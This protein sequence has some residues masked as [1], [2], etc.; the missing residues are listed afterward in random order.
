MIFSAIALIIEGFW[1]NRLLPFITL[2]EIYSSTLFIMLITGLFSV[3]VPL[4]FYSLMDESFLRLTIV[5]IVSFLSVTIFSYF[6]GLNRLE[7]QLVFKYLNKF[8][9]RF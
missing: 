5:T 6:L 4:M 7:K 8:G 9:I 3:I 2:R 1:L